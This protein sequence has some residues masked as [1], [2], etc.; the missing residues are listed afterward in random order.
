MLLNERPKT[1]T[2]VEVFAGGNR[3]PNRFLTFGGID[4]SR[5]FEDDFPDSVIAKL[6]SDVDNMAVPGVSEVIDKGSGVYGHA[7][8]HE[9]RGKVLVDDERL[10]PLWQ[11]IAELHLPLL[12]HVGEPVWFYEPIDGN[13]EFLQWQTNSYRWNLSGAVLSPAAGNTPRSSGTTACRLRQAPTPVE[14]FS[15]SVLP[16]VTV[17]ATPLPVGLPSF[18][19]LNMG[20]VNTNRPCLC[21][22]SRAIERGNLHSTGISPFIA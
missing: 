20:S 2:C 15:T 22:L 17:P 10:M 4:F 8:I 11:T 9:P 19:F 3:Y 18:S 16:G 12:L 6:R 13:H 5:R 21:P 7:L 1:L 14:V